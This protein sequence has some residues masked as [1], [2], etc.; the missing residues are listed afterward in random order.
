MTDC[1]HR[2]QVVM[3]THMMCGHAESKARG[4]LPLSF[5]E[6]CQL[7]RPKG[8]FFAQTERLLIQKQTS[9]EYKP[10]PKSCGGCGTVKKRSDVLQFVYPYWHGGAAGD[11]LR[12]SIRSIEQHYQ[13]KA[14]IT[15]VG[16]RPPWFQGHVINQRRIG[17]RHTNRAFRD[18]LA[19]M[20][21]IAT[22]PEIDS[23]FVW[24]MDDIYFVKPVTFDVLATPRA[25]PYRPSSKNSWQNRKANTMRVLTQ[26][27]L[28]THDYATH[29]PHF[30]EKAK[31]KELYERFD[32]GKNTLLWEVLYGNVYRTKPQ[33]TRPFFCRIQKR[34]DIDTIKRVTEHASVLNHTD[35]AWC[36]GMRAYLAELLPTPASGEVEVSG[37]VPQ[38]RRVR[39]NVK[40][41]K[42][43]P[44]HTH[45][46]YIEAQ[47]AKENVE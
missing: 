10:Q 42:R 9:G 6:T 23:E 1:I 43:R 30:A 17:K 33:R 36:E 14:K 2:R 41:V 32:L 12:W 34:M 5:C 28:T 16:D 13:G 29:L 11:E 45:K 21:T 7:R 20:W 26:A 40:T 47:R 44:L 22:H 39:K 27:G 19:K 35:P 18:M 24:M 38:F 3:K 25:E 37:H 15:L 46:A 8:D 31:L 4:V